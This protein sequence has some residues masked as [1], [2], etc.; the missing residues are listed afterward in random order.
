MQ[1]AATTQSALAKERR[2]LREQQKNAL[3][4]TFSQIYDKPFVAFTDEAP[5]YEAPDPEQSGS[6]NTGHILLV[7]PRFPQLTAPPQRPQPPPPCPIPAGVE[8][9]SRPPS[10]APPHGRRLPCC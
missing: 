6:K 8:L 3:L 5:Y 4:D 2:E 9:A 10:R 7:I 1:R